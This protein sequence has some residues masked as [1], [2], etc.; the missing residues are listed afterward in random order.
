MIYEVRGSVSPF[1]VL[2]NLYLFLV[3]RNP[4]R[5]KNETY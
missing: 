2:R 1:L 5:I 4:L 3:T